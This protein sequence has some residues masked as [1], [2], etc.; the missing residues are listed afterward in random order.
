MKKNINW[1]IIELWNIYSKFAH[2]FKNST[3]DSLIGLSDKIF[4]MYKKKLN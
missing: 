4:N 1:V 3:I 2:T